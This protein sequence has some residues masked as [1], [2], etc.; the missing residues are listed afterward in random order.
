MCEFEQMEAQ[1]AKCI[2][3]LGYGT[4]RSVSPQKCRILIAA[5]VGSAE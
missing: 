5:D 3:E 4:W 2:E 1:M